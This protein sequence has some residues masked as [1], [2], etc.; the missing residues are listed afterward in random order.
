MA[1]TVERI[2]AVTRRDS[3]HLRQHA[4]GALNR[5]SVRHRTDI[6]DWTRQRDAC[7]TMVR[8]GDKLMYQ[9]SCQ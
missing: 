6:H 2:R 7:G 9:G 1:P 3:G 5:K 8:C 4:N